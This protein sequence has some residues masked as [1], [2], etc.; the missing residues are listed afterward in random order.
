MINYDIKTYINIININ[1]KRLISGAVDKSMIIS[2]FT[3]DDNKIMISY[4]S[5]Y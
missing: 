3:K 2:W 1:Q 5:Y 4:F